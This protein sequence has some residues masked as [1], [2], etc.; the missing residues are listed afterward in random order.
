MD[1]SMTFTELVDAHGRTMPKG[2]PPVLVAHPYYG[3]LGYCVA[4]KGFVPPKMRWA[5]TRAILRDDSRFKI[6]ALQK[7][8]TYAPAFFTGAL[9]AALSHDPFGGP[10]ILGMAIS[11]YDGIVSARGSGA[12]QDVWLVM[13]TAIG[14]VTLS[15]YDSW[16]SAY[17]IGSVPSVTAY[18]DGG[19]GGAVHTTASSG[20]WLSNPGGS[21]KKY[22]ASVG[23]SITSITGFSVAMLMDNLWSGSY[24]V[25]SATGTIN[26]T[27]DVAVT[28]WAGTAAAGNMMMVVMA[29]TLT[30]TVAP[31]LTTTYLDQAGGSQTTISIFPATGV[32]VNRVVCNTLHNSATVVASSPFMPMT[33]GSAYGVRQ[34]SQIVNSATCTAGNVHHKIVR[35]LIIMPTIAANSYIEQDTTLN[36]GNM[37]ELVNASQ[38]VGC[39]SWAAFSAGT[40]TATWSSMIRMVEG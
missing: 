22:I 39:L 4:G 31:T 37:V 7:I 1:K 25:L 18:T 33:N 13:A 6:K 40:T 10:A 17:N 19:T 20:S 14:G 30:H 27:T 21:N 5:S 15:W 23:L 35:P 11:T 24:N 32:L 12:S 9:A 3:E 34:L 2:C 36:I 26:P 28:R 29:G 8:E 16:Q 38:V